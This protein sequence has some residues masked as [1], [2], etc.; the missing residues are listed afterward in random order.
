MQRRTDIISVSFAAAF[1][2]CHNFTYN[3]FNSSTFYCNVS[4]FN[5]NIGRCSNK[6]YFSYIFSSTICTS[7]TA[8]T[9][10]RLVFY[11]ILANSSGRI[12]T[13]RNSFHS[14]MVL[15]YS[16]ATTL[17][18]NQ[19]QPFRTDL[20]RCRKSDRSVAY[21]SIHHGISDT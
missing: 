21:Q 14:Y 10:Y 11:P 15:D 9:Q 19:I 16:S 12:L 8:F 13:T 20:V 3:H 4:V 5:N 2:Q 18:E 6:P 17:F 1:C 7:C